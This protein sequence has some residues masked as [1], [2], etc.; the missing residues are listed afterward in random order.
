MPAKIDTTTLNFLKQLKNNNNKVW[1]EKNRKL[2][3]VAKTNFLEFTAEFINGLEKTDPAVKGLDPRK[4]IFRIN[5]DIRFSKD[6]SPYK[7]NMGCAVSKGGK[8]VSSAGYYFHV[9]P[10]ASFSAGGSYMPMP[11]QL[12]AIRQEIDYNFQSFKKIISH[13]SF[14]KYFPELDEIEKLKTV[15]KGYNAGNPA[16]EYLKHKSFIVSKQYTD[17]EITAP[18]FLKDLLASCKAMYPFILFLNNAMD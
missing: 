11:P 7:T 16:I 17:K 6:K 5:R 14:Q 9:E 2:Y 10:G 4:T 3:E 8:L 13:K 15:P 12:Q 1:F 18:G